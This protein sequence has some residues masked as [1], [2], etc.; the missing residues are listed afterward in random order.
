MDWFHY[1]GASAMKGLRFWEY[2]I[3]IIFN[4]LD[5]RKQFL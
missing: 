4:D 5:K 1:D 3:Q 2:L